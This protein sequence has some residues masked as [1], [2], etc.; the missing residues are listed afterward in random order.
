M[1]AR[2][3]VVFLCLCLVVFA[4]PQAVTPGGSDEPCGDDDDGPGDDDTTGDD[5]TGDDDTGDDDTGVPLDLISGE[6]ELEI[7]SVPSDSCEYG[8]PPLAPGDTLDAWIDVVDTDN[9]TKV[10]VELEDFAGIESARHAPDG[11]S[12]GGQHLHGGWFRRGV[13]FRAD[14]DV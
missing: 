2:I 3:A 14:S 1:R 7:S 4:C 11:G 10:F 6:Y 12:E 13:H 5:G 8:T 9:G